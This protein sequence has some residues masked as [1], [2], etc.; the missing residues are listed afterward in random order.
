MLS[1]SQIKAARGLIG[2]NQEELAKISNLSV[3]TIKKMEKDDK[4]IGKASINTIK[5]IKQS[6]EK[7]GIKFIQ[8]EEDGIT[9]IGVQYYPI[10][11]LNNKLK[12]IETYRNQ[13]P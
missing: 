12:K 11:N 8:P 1:S 13:L 4:E 2:I 6:L 9:G 7:M 10:K 5:Q 3:L